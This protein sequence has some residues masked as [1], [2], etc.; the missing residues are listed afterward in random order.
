[1]KNNKGF[2]SVFR[3]SLPFLA[4]ALIVEL[5]PTLWFVCQK[6][7]FTLGDTL[8]GLGDILFI[9]L[10][11]ALL[12]Q[13]IYW[14]AMRN[15]KRQ[16]LMDLLPIKKADEVICEFVNGM[17]IMVTPLLLWVVA[18][19]RYFNLYTKMVNADERILEFFEQEGI[20]LNYFTDNAALDPI[21]T[22]GMVFIV[23]YAIFI[24][25]KRVS[26][27]LLATYLGTFAVYSIAILGLLLYDC[28]PS[29][30]LASGSIWINIYKMLMYGI[31]NIHPVLSIAI[32]LVIAGLLLAAAVHIQKCPYK[33]DTGAFC[34]TIVDV[35]FTGIVTI[36]IIVFGLNMNGITS[37]ALRICFTIFITI[38]VAAGTFYLIRPKRGTP[39]H[40]GRI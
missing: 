26:N 36:W 38:A 34:H 30:M 9:Y 10:L 37:D 20:R 14:F 1:M 16:D 23:C 4:V 29:Q 40:K 12:V 5:L 32:V 17:I 19:V 15:G 27:H 24:L 7:F 31:W 33:R 35:I 28:I 8:A 21:L 39:L 25:I 2:L 3:Q 6:D 18:D 22:W 13:G 11:Y